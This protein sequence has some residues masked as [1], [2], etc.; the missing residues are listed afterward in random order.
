MAVVV[1]QIVIEAQGYR[2][3]PQ[4]WKLLICELTP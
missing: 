1:A 4:N 2:L 3:V